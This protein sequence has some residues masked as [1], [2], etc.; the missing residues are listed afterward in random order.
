M[1]DRIREDL[2]TV[3]EYRRL[4]HANERALVVAAL[5]IPYWIFPVSDRFALCVESSHFHRVSEELAL[6]EKERSPF[7]RFRNFRRTRAEPISASLFVATWIMAL[8]FL[9]QKTGP[10]WWADAGDVSPGA[11]FQ[12]G[13]WWRVVTALT[14]HADLSH[15]GANLATGLLFAFFLLPI[16][17]VGATWSA[18]LLSGALGNLLNAYFYRGEPHNSIGASTAVFGALGILVGAQTASQ[19]FSKRS[20]RIWEIILPI[21]AGAALLAFLGSGGKDRA[22][23]Y[24]AHFWGFLAGL[25]MGVLGEVFRVKKR[26]SKKWQQVLAGV[27]A[28][29]P[30][31]CWLAAVLHR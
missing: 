20:P 29:A 11:I 14:L 24:M 3:G 27:A 23:D 4:R 25:P 31:L 6:Y 1:E 19:L 10:V 15:I 21:G 13:Q 22:V 16:F 8:F 30:G 28:I 9:L 26:L 5:G 17:G 2:A 12:Q 18:I 7:R